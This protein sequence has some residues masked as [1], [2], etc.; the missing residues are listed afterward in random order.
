VCDN[1]DPRQNLACAGLVQPIS[2]KPQIT[3]P[4]RNFT[5]SGEIPPLSGMP[6]TTD[7]TSATN[8][9]EATRRLYL[10][11]YP[12]APDQPVRRLFAE[13][14]RLFSG[15]H[16]EYQANDLIYHDYR[17]TLQVTVCY[18]DIFAGRHARE[19]K[20]LGARHFQLGLAG[21]LY[22]DT[23]YLKARADRA[24]TGAKYTYCHVL[25]S[26]ALAASYLP[27]IGFTVEEIDTVL[28][29]IRRTGPS[30]PGTAQRFHSPEEQFL[31]S[32]VASAD[33]IAQMAAEDYPGELDALYAEFTESDDY[34][35]VPAPRRAFKSAA[36]LAVRTPKFWLKVV[37]PKIETDFFGVHRYLEGPDGTNPWI[38][39]IGSNLA[40]ITERAAAT[41]T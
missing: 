26:C 10:G 14:D 1:N 40:R 16:P 41:A 15:Q 33:Y 29:A 7:T 11:L 22:H 38:E 2:E 31:A 35:G 30:P 20:A 4:Q 5:F 32:A 18:A 21:A 17:H 3:N 13:A 24:G 9:A 6:L 23:G 27:A 12:D 8:V 37:K 25:R 39:A 19:P 36:D 34:A 28:G